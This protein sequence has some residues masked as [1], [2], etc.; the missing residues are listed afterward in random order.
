ME[1]VNCIPLVSMEMFIMFVDK[2]LKTGS[3]SKENN[4]KDNEKQIEENV[5]VKNEAPEEK[6]KT[7]RTKRKK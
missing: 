6:T 3:V 2:P 1:D 7:K 5:D 4:I